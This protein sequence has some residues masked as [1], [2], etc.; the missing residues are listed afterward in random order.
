MTADL[1]APRGTAAGGWTERPSLPRGVGRARPPGGHHAGGRRGRARPRARRTD[2]GGAAA[3]GVR[4]GDPAR[5]GRARRGRSGLDDRAAGHPC[6]Q[7][8]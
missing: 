5:P 3:Q 2:R 8:R 1:T 6:G 4:P 7:R